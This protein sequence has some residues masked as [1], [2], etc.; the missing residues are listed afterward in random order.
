MI[1]HDNR[2]VLAKNTYP[3]QVKLNVLGSSIVL[4]EESEIAASVRAIEANVFL[5]D[6]SKVTGQVIAGSLVMNGGEVIKPKRDIVTVFGPKRYDRTKGSPNNYDDSFDLPNCVNN[7]YTLKIVN[8]DSS[9]NKRISSGT[10]KVN[11][12]LIVDQSEFNQNVGY[13][14]KQIT[15]A[16]SNTL[17]IRLT[18]TPNTYFYS[19]NSW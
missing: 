6:K 2:I 14:E 13:I 15:L 4:G 11:G 3:S 1:L 10:V 5:E 17:Q 9:G 16:E 18:S 8:G 7:P 12:T 19:R